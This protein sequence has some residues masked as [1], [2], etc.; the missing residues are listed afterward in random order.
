MEG[1]PYTGQTFSDV[2]RYDPFNNKWRQIRDYTL[3]KTINTDNPKSVTRATGFGG[4]TLDVGYVGF[5][6]MPDELQRAQEDY[7]K[8]QP[9]EGSSVAG[10]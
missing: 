9:W 10:F 1:G 6:I 2:Y 3:D 7:W 8:Y 4:V 5:G